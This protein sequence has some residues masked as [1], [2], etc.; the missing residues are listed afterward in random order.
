MRGSSAYPQLY[1][2]N[3]RAP[4]G[5][6]FMQTI[7]IT[8]VEEIRYYS[9]TEATQQWGTGNTGG[10]IEVITDAQRTRPVA[11]EGSERGDRGD[12]SGPSYTFEPY[13]PFTVS[14][15]VHFNGA[16]S[17][18]ASPSELGNFWAPHYAVG[19]GLGLT[20]TKNVTVVANVDYNRFSFEDDAVL[21]FLES[22][23]GSYR[24]RSREAVEVN[25]APMT[26]FNLSGN[27]KF[28]PSGG[29]FRPYGT[30][31]FGYMRMTA[32]A[33]SVTGPNGTDLPFSQFVPGRADGG[34]ARE[35]SV[36]LSVGGGVDLGLTSQIDVFADA[37]YVIGLRGPRYS[38]IF[39]DLQLLNTQYYPFRVGMSLRLSTVRIFQY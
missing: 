25:G 8:L 23:N 31:G 14:P 26:L 21:S 9:P 36:S 18:V 20:A 28:H 15:V 12:G 5:L 32:G 6:D 11:A 16:S 34:D 3:L 19:G 22:S 37:R 7:S 4:T 27:V 13:Q 29:R 30:L 17:I 38:D 2:D 39:G 1:V 33:F 10:A 24:L 35:N